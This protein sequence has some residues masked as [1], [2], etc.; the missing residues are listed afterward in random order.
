MTATIHQE[1]ANLQMTTTIHQEQ[2]NLQMTATIH[3]EQAN[4]QMTTTIQSSF[5][6]VALCLVLCAGYPNV[7]K[8]SLLN[9]LVGRKV[10]ALTA[11]DSIISVAYSTS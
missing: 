10:S 2:A 1:Q 11:V 5:K 6:T 3:Q 8:S 4:L 9:G 7:G